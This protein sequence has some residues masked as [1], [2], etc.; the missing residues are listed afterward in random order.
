MLA[1]LAPAFVPAVTVQLPP[2]A[3]IGDGQ[4]G[5]DADPPATIMIMCSCVVA[6]LGVIAGVVNFLVTFVFVAPVV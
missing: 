6:P 3:L 2:V 5:P 1:P 4:V